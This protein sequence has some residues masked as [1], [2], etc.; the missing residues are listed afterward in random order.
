MSSSKDGNYYVLQSLTTFPFAGILLCST[1]INNLSSQTV[2]NQHN[3]AKPRAVLSL[4][5]LWSL[6]FKLSESFTHLCGFFF[7]Q[8][9]KEKKEKIPAM[10][11]NK[12]SCPKGSF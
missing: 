8:L 12:H 5:W 2:L 3:K 10:D 4:L 7:L 9:F 1:D 6:P 11:T